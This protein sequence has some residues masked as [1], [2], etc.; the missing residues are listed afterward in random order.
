MIISDYLLRK[1]SLTKL[2]IEHSCQE[3]NKHEKELQV[4]YVKQII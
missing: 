1:T 3:G 2:V 4:Q